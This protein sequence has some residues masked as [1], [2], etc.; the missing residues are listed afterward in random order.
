MR[1]GKFHKSNHY[2]KI[3]YWE[4]LNEPDF[5]H[6]LSPQLYTKIFDAVVGE[7]KKVSPSTKFV[8]LALAYNTKSGMV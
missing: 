6:S 4:V 5:E 7:M 8:G 2:Y 3:P 1:L